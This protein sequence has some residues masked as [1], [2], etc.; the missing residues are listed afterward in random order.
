MG[1]RGEVSDFKVPKQ[2]ADAIKNTKGLHVLYSTES[3]R[4]QLACRGSVVLP[5]Q[6]AAVSKC[7][8]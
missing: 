8:P 4:Q 5:V 2:V 1:P 3:F 6:D 7:A